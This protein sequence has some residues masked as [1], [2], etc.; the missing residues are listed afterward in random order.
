MMKKINLIVT[1]LMMSFVV[2]VALQVKH[3]VVAKNKTSSEAGISWITPE[4]IDVGKIEKGKPVT[5]TFEFKNSGDTPVLISSVKGQ[6]GCTTVDYSKE[7]VE[8]N[9]KGFVKATYNAANTGVFDKSISV[10]T[11]NSGQ[12]IQLHIKGEVY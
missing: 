5:A 3:E 7:V 4:T 8:A 9:K 2:A 12:Q 10:A 6:C 1:F 11:N